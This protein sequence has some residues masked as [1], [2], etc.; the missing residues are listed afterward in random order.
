MGCL[1]SKEE[2]ER[3]DWRERNK[4]ENGKEWDKLC[5]EDKK[6]PGLVSKATYYRYA[7]FEDKKYKAQHPKAN[8]ASKRAGFKHR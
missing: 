2:K 1:Q 3:A 4:T 6:Y 8:T 7:L 5:S